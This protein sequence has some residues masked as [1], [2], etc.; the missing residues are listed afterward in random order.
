[1]C[2]KKMKQIIYVIML[3]LFSVVVVADKLVYDNTLSDGN[4][5]TVNK[6]TFII[7]V[8]PTGSRIVLTHDNE[9]TPINIYECETAYNITRVCFYNTTY[10]IKRNVY[11]ANVRAYNIE[12]VIVI[13]RTVGNNNLHVYER[14]Q[15]NTTINNT[16]NSTAFDF[17]Y[18]ESFSPNI[19]LSDLDC[20]GCTKDG[21][22]LS[23]N[24]RLSK[25]ESK[26][27]SFWLTPL[28]IVDETFRLKVKYFNGLYDKEVF[29]DPLPLK[30]EPFFK[31][32]F[33]LSKSSVYIGE[34]VNATINT[35][36]YASERV[37]YKV[38]IRLPEGVEMDEYP[39]SV[40]IINPK[41]Y[42]WSGEVDKINGSAQINLKLHGLLQGN[43]EIIAK[44]YFE[45]YN[46]N[47]SLEKPANLEVKNR[48]LMMTASF[49]DNDQFESKENLQL[50]VY[51]HNP[52]AFADVRNLTIQFLTNISAFNNATLESLNKTKSATILYRKI[53]LP[54]TNT[55]ISLPFNVIVDYETEAF[56][57]QRQEFKY[58][59]RLKPVDDL[60]INHAL[61]SGTVEGGV[62]VDVRVSVQN[63]R[64]VSVK[65]VAVSDVVPPSFGVEGVSNAVVVINKEDTLDVYSY[66]I[67]PPKVNTDTV[68]IINT[69]ASY[70]DGVQKRNFSYYKSS[71]IRVIPEKLVITATRTVPSQIVKGQKT[72]IGHVLV[73]TADRSARNLRIELPLSSDYDIIGDR[74]Y[75]VA[76]LDPGERLTLAEIEKI[77]PKYNT[78]MVLD[79]AFA[80]YEDE[81]SNQFN[82][83]ISSV[84]IRPLYGRSP[85]PT[86]LVEKNAT[87][88]YNNTFVVA[89]QL[90]N[91]GEMSALNINLSDQG[92]IWKI[93]NLDD[94]G[95]LILTYNVTQAYG[96]NDTGR[97]VISYGYDGEI[98]TTTSNRL[99][100]ETYKPEESE[101]IIK[102][103]VLEQKKEP[104]WN[105][106]WKKI[107]GLLFWSLKPKETNNQ[108]EQ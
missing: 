18:S 31:T 55:S 22:G 28:D 93:G 98:H 15:V 36:N 43:S 89:L 95:F 37:K 97:A 34:V 58:N 61:S 24:G 49:K 21:S 12:P 81:H 68:Y 70:Y 99:I 60:Q 62:P 92:R 14:T 106:I 35:T 2:A 90:K 74:T 52:S 77:R 59:I 79:N 105:R 94:R 26:V 53:N 107:K 29:S 10:D 27:F 82:T 50:T 78:T 8:N 25:D 86:V 11:K 38:G 103:E 56:E 1:M 71:E 57:K 88:L 40:T 108:T 45:A 32:R 19:N 96:D 83:T 9:I 51:L 30:S 47:F 65:G 39:A 64:K 16:G 44:F 5:F 80:T 66:T 4:S 73:N 41:N 102:E 63:K 67:I 48:N 104:I 13:T 42:K 33:V 101:R 91:I 3:V 23:W 7:S 20:Y 87:R 54:E 69:T 76:R 84:S 75:K 6:K 17:F 46:K 72:K 100:V 85:G